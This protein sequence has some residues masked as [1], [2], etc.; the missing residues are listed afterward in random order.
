MGVASVTRLKLRSWR[1]LPPFAL[2][3][4]ASA[5]QAARTPGFLGGAILNDRDLTFWTLTAWENEAA[6]KAFMMTGAHARVMPKLIM[7]CDEAAVARWEAEALPGWD[8]AVAKLKTAGRPSRVKFP[9]VRHKDL[10]F[11]RPVMTRS[12]PIKARRA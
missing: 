6:L 1:Y 3:T 8:E 5:R 9:S 4:L 10:D 11:P 2:E 7:W 12:V